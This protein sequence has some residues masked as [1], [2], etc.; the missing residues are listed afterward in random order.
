MVL[1][2]EKT[3][4][5]TEQA[6]ADPGRIHDMVG[7]IKKSLAAGVAI[8]LG[9]MAFIHSGGGLQGS[10]MFSVGL[11]AVIALGM[12]LY[13][14]KIAYIEIFKP[15]YLL[16]MLL[17][18]VIGAMICG[19]VYSLCM[20]PSE[21]AINRV[22]GYFTD[23][24]QAVACGI[25]IYLAVEGYKRTNQILAIVFPVAVFVVSGAE[26][27]IA[28]SFYI[29]AAPDFRIERLLWLLVIVIGNSVGS[30]VMHYLMRD[31]PKKK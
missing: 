17:F 11:I 10:V 5:R 3:E 16:W 25:L 27:C 24:W 23:F 19:F 9:C 20:G 2:K 14:G 21:I 8:S 13:T 30:I 15:S 29:G 18:N 28:D 6:A 22:N 4:T 1:E 31:I 7:H 12:L 26:H